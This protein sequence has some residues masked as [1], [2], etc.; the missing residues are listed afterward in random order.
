MYSKW[1][2]HLVDEQAKQNFR[3]QVIS[4]K[5]VL[6]RQKQISE[7]WE[8]ALDRSETDPRQFDTPNWDYRQAW[9]NGFRAA[10]LQH[11]TLINLDQ[12]DTDLN[13]R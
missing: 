6:D 8:K 13:E 9:K 7:E 1:T 10:L 12:Q 11:K 5:D 3:L 2:S 4:A